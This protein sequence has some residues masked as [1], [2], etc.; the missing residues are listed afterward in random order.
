M[1]RSFVIL[2]L[3]AVCGCT[4]P[5]AETDKVEL[6]FWTI[7]L[8]PTYDDYINDLIQEYESEN[9]QVKLHWVDLP[10]SASRQKFM[11]SIAAGRPP[12]LVNTSTEFCNTLA[13][14]GALTALSDKLS[15]EQI[16]QYFPNLWE[17]TEF[18]GEVYAFPWYVTTQ[19]V[20]Y[21]KSILK[22]AGLE[23]DSPPQTLEELDKQARQVTQKTDAVG[24]MP[25]I[26]IWN[27][28][29]MEGSPF[30]D[31]DKLQPLFTAPESVAVL[32]R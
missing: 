13:Q 9:P 6:T 11:A 28:W 29:S 24:L 5:A 19:V 12:D 1:R 3:L 32:Q 4:P 25:A 23:P 16:A 27:D 8:S 30:I 10:Q 17:A 18:E 7:S 31:T 22:Q 14:N 15:S 20:M 21:N 2:L 26:R